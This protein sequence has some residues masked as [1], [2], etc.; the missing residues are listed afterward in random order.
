MKKIIL[1]TILM[2]AIVVIG[3]GSKCAS[4]ERYKSF[5][6][7]YPG[8]AIKHNIANLGETVSDKNGNQYRV[9]A[10][11]KHPTIDRWVQWVDFA[12]PGKEL[13]G[14]CVFASYLRLDEKNLTMIM[15]DCMEALTIITNWCIR[16]NIRVDDYIRSA[17]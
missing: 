13:T 2:L 7:L 8:I 17:L 5:A 1:T 6:E 15:Y 9:L 12:A 10:E 11:C 16:N 14:G 3:L 4:S